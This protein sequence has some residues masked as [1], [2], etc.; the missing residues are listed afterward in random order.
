MIN[1]TQIKYFLSKL[2]LIGTLIA[3]ACSTST[4]LQTSKIYNEGYIVDP[5]ALK[6]I[7]PGSSREQVLLALG[8]PSIK[9]IF[10]NEVFYYISQ[11]QYRRAQFT[12]TQIMERHILAIYFNK[13]E[14]V[15]KIANYDLKD[16][17]LLNSSSKTTP[18]GGKEES[19]LSQL[20]SGARIILPSLT[21]QSQ[22]PHIL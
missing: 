7:P 20:I 12:K 9:T 1:I 22:V 15:S 3:S 2:C 11:I 17:K 21:S 10:N 13:Q 6:T 19:F 4:I 8:S 14:K 18:T 5:Q 16:G